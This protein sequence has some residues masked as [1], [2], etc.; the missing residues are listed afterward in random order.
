MK[1]CEIK[2][3]KSI[4]VEILANFTGCAVQVETAKES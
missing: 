1:Y 4:C 3:V 2:T